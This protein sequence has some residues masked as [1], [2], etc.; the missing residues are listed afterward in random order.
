MSPVTHL[1]AFGNRVDI[2]CPPDGRYH[3]DMPSKLRLSDRRRRHG[4]QPFPDPDTKRRRWAE[5]A[6]DRMAI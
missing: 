4:S 5:E 1:I 6:Q 2:G 3:R